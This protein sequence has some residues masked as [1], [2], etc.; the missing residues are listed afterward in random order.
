[1]F[2]IDMAI[3]PPFCV[4]VADEH[5][6]LGDMSI[7]RRPFPGH[8]DFAEGL[9]RHTARS[10]FDLAVAEELAPDHGVTLPLLFVKP[11][12]RIP[13]VP[14]YVNVN[15]EPAPSPA[16]CRALAGAIGEFIASVRPANERVGVVA[17]GGLSH[18]LNLP[19]M[20]TV[21]EDFDRHV[22]ETIGS[23]NPGRLAE[24]SAEELAE[25][26]GNGGLEILNWMMMAVAA[27]EPK[28]DTI[29]YEPIPQWFTGMAGMAMRV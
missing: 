27:G 10:G 19:Q 24:L 26:A 6:P 25:R 23:G 9:V 8:R 1:M 16:R 17:T 3:Q 28:G 22:L 2:N 14:L 15:M 20:G 11:W 18:W 7:P 13:V 5:V 29:F 12:G 21:A 4:G